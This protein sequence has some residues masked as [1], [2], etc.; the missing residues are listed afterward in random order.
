MSAEKIIHAVGP[1]YRC[2]E[3]EAQILRAE[4]Q[5]AQTY[6]NILST[7]VHLRLTTLAIPTIS[8]GALA[9]PRQSAA[10]IA[11]TA[12]RKFIK[13]NHGRTL[14][15]VSFLLWPAGGLDEEH[16]AANFE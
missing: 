12:V 15:R 7:A 4:R 11:L 9:F 8:T 14:K 13:A 6:F 5:L 2:V 10:R 16:Y 3:T 1:D